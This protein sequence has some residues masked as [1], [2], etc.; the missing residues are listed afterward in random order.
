MHDTIIVGGGHNGLSCAA[1][2][3]RAGKRVLVLEANAQ[4]GGFLVTDEI[5]GAPGYRMN[6]FAFEFPFARL[7]PSVADELNLARH[8]LRW[9][10]PDP[11]N[12]YLGPDG[13][14]FSLYRD[15]D[16]TCA[17]IARLSR[18]DAVAYQRLMR[19]L[20]GIAQT[21]IPYLADHPTRPSPRTLV[22]LLVHAARNRRQLLPAVRYLLCSP[23]EIMEE[24][25]R[26]EIRAFIAMNVA[27]G[28]FRPLDEPANTSILVYF[29]ILHLVNLQRPVGGAG[30]FSDALAA[31]ISA[32]GGEVRTCAPVKEILVHGGRATGVKLASG[33]EIRAGEVVAAIDPT[34]LFK[35]LLDPSAISSELRDE[36]DR[37]RV[38]SSGVSHF[39]AD[40]AVSRR[41]TFPDHSVTDEQLAG[42][43]FAPTVDYVENVMTAVKRGELAEELPF[44][45]A[46]P[47]V[48]DRT[49]VPPDSEGESIFVWVGAVPYDLAG[50]RD[51][52]DV[53][54]GYLDRVVDHLEQYS[55]G[56]RDTILGASIRSPHEFNQPW[57][58]KG[59]SR[60]V[61][62]IP[63]QM[64]PWRPSPLLSG[65]TTPGLEGL[66]RSGHGTHPMSGSS[67]WP[68][69]ITA[70][71]ML[72]H[73]RRDRITAQLRNTTTTS[74]GHL[75]SSRLGQRNGSTADRY[76]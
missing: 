39:K 34:N 23:L 21:A 62:L 18:K 6:T 27:T 29:A 28:S 68:G 64:G 8:G 50:G 76:A 74:R 9:T 51:W 13:A 52:Q 37:M 16:R 75:S 7:K 66:W 63:S 72:K 12:T 53:K 33:E 11:H 44:F 2:L 26:E 22:D 36:V 48:L 69:R 24:L 47:S 58:Y 5:P 32:R 1:Y 3:A 15:L 30:A 65:Y 10:S 35:D 38:L 41:P 49:L 14:T 56:V 71:T 45:I 60:S 17:T 46:L 70:K 42:L 57:A 4:V 59:S 67:G 61:D 54:A 19:A 20:M 25:E 43:S 55:P 40:L 31:A 73:A